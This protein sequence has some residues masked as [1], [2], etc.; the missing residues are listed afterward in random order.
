LLRDVEEI[1]IEVSQMQKSPQIQE[2]LHGLP[3]KVEGKYPQTKAPQARHVLG[4][5]RDKDL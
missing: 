4:T 1:N 5:L 2:V 3:Y